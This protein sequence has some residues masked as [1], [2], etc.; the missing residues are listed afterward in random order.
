M[1]R[2]I[3]PINAYL[4][5]MTRLAHPAPAGTI[6]FRPV[7]SADLP[8]LA[9][10]LTR[11]HWRD[12][13]GDPEAELDKIRDMVE[14]RD[15]TRPYLFDLDDGPPGF[16]QVWTI[17]DWQTPEQAEET[18]WVMLLP[19]D[20]VGVD[21]AIADPHRLGQG[22]GTRVLIAFIAKLRAEGFETLII[23]PDPANTRAVSCYTR[24]GFRPIP[25]LIG[26]TDDSLLMQFH[27]D[28][29]TS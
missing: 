17:A 5:T 11:P 6:R 16:I 24:A 25:E 2:D 28:A 1:P 29:Q 12:W 14:G 20:A 4:R 3:A 23:D 21:L 10:W 8:M 26:R 7:T 9:D 13:W 22:V 27:P 18:P 19:E 15:T